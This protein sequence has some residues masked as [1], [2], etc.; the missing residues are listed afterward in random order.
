M[1]PYV[2]KVKK[3]TVLIV[4]NSSNVR[5]LVINLLSPIKNIEVVGEAGTVMQAIEMFEKTNPDVVILDLHY[6]E[7]GGFDVLDHIKIHRPGT[8]VIVLTNYP[9]LPYRKRCIEAGAEYFFDKSMEF[10]KIAEVINEP[11][12]SKER[13]DI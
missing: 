5:R 12:S 1:L 7:G 6:P 10:D 2:L 13:Q 4:D 8:M 9:L 3:R 11:T